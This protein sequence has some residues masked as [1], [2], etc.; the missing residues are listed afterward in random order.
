MVIETTPRYFKITFNWNPKLVEKVKELPE[1][2][3]DPREKVWLVPS[4]HRLAVERFAHQNRFSWAKATNEPEPDFTIPPMPE[5]QIDIPLVRKPF[6]YQG[7]GIAYS[8]IHRRLIIGDQPGLGKTGQAIGTIVGADL[9][10]QQTKAFPAFPCLVI[11]PS[12]L[13]INWQR[14]WQIWT[15]RNM[16]MILEDANRKNWHLYWEANMAKV[17]IVNYESLKKYFV[18]SIEKGES[19]KLRLNHVKFDPRINIFKS[20]IIDES[21]RCKSTSTQQSKFTKGICSGKDWILALTG[22]PVINKPKDLI[23]QLGI[24]DQ[25]NCFNGYKNFVERYCSGMKEA[26]NLK[27][28]NYKLNLHCFYRRDKSEV[29]KDLPAKM[30]QVVICEIDNRKEYQAAENDL[31]NYLKQYKDASDEK[32]QSAMRG[33]IMVRIGILRNISARG[34]IKDVVDYIQDTLESGEK[35]IIFAHLK[36]VIAAIKK[37]FPHAVS[38]TGD[39]DMASRQRNV[40]LF[41]NNPKTNLIVCSIKAAGVGL[42]LTASSRVAFIEFPWTAADCD[43]CEDRAHR[44]GQKDSV[45]CTYFLGKQ[46][47]DEHIYQII[48]DKR[49]IADAVT[50][51]KDI[52]EVDIVSAI[53]NLFNN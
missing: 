8:L 34:K 44:I 13:K 29:L 9:M 39:D 36:E 11:C 6:P 10:F 40:D 52:V 43:Q 49:S 17:F 16:A 37:E 35:L 46:T 50:G 15:G 19:D 3:F 53:A 4:S 7:N 42:T 28:L 22:T 51:A 23:S 20:I 25:M 48:Q 32:I 31:I 18:K 2:R 24:I 14:E 30:R 26:S 27:E 45:T 21:H 5:L 47:I 38:I 41:Q 33:E 1:R 12:S